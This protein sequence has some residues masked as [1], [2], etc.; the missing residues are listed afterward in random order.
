MDLVTVPSRD[1]AFP[2]VVLEAMALGRLPVVAFS[3][4]SLLSSSAIRAS[5][6]RRDEGFGGYGGGG[7]R[8]ARTDRP[9]I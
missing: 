8:L 7:A 2:F 4:P 5:L 6:C 9:P 3:L 1:D